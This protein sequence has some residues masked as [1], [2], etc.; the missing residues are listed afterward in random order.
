[1]PGPLSQP[2]ARQG[3]RV[4][5]GKTALRREKLKSR[6]G[7]GEREWSSTPK[8]AQRKPNAPKDRDAE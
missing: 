7:M 1:M 2:S 6:E 3:N 4:I 8:T 5:S